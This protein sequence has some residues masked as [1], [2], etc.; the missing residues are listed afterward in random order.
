[1]NDA[2][3]IL[4]RFS[5]ISAELWVGAQE[6]VQRARGFM[7]SAPPASPAAAARL[8]IAAGAS[9]GRSAAPTQPRRLGALAPDTLRCF[10]PWQ[11]L[12]RI[13]MR[14]QGVTRYSRR[15]D[16]PVPT[17]S[18]PPIELALI[19]CSKPAIMRSD[20]LAQPDG[21]SG[22]ELPCAPSAR[23]RLYHQAESLGDGPELNVVIDGLVAHEGRLGYRI[24]A[25]AGTGA[26]VPASKWP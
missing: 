11:T 23:R 21:P 13:D 20:G 18:E 15:G 3:L 5:S 4:I 26:V 1:M 16:R 24:A 7:T 9:R 22:E 17:A 2:G 6:L 14:E 25:T 10:S 8:S 19:G 12:S